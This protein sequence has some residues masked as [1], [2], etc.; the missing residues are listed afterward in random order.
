VN[1]L[2]SQTDSKIETSYFRTAKPGDATKAMVT[3]LT[4]PVQ[5]FLFFPN[6]NKVLEQIDGYFD[7][8]V[9]TAD[10][11]LT[12]EVKDQALAAGL[13]EELKLND[14]G[15]VVF[16]RGEEQPV[17]FKMKTD[18]DRGAKRDLRRLDELV[19]KN[20]LKAT[21]GT[22]NA[23]FVMGHGEASQRIKDDD[24]RKMSQLRKYMQNQSYKLNDLSVV[25]GL[26]DKVP[27]DADVLILAGPQKPLLPE[28]E[29]SLIQWMDQGGKLIVL[30][31]GRGDPLAGLLDH[32]GLR[33]NMGLLND[34]KRRLRN[35]SPYIVATDRYGTHTT[36]SA[37]SKAKAPVVLPAPIGLEETST[38]TTKRTVLVRSYG[39]A[40]ADSNRNGAQDP[41]E[42]AK[43]H[44][45]AYAVEGGVE[46]SEWRAVVVGN[47]GF[48]SDQ[49]LA[50]G[51]GA[52]AALFVDSLRW[53]AGE[54]EV[55]GNT[56]SE[57]D[58]KI[59]HSP[60]GQKWWFWGTIF[61][62]PLLILGLG[63]GRFLLRRRMS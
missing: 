23:Y 27:E 47:Q 30:V 1:Y 42:K 61:A 40:F 25:Q 16:R 33:A 55:V 63:I 35:A 44:N 22:L 15:W 32:L 51:W 36:V 58:V 57:E 19:Q 12:V 34:P 43:V 52:G 60:G 31:D 14:N 11:K 48:V 39:T 3:S 38:G 62:V 26:A 49:A 9:P 37:L 53:L 17:K 7:E 28:E 24:W 10:G 4:E 2:A 41:D 45:M 50:Q 29:R 20:L 13:A 46:G 59:D 8:L 54:E 18:L 21:R 56:E 6:G 5:V